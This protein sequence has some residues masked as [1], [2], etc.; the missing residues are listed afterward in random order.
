MWFSPFL[1]TH[2]LTCHHSSVVGASSSLEAEFICV[3]LEKWCCTCPEKIIG[4]K[5]H[6][7]DLFK[8]CLQVF[9][10][11]CFSWTNFQSVC[12]SK[13]WTFG[14]IKSCFQILIILVHTLYVGVTNS[15]CK[16]FRHVDPS[17]HINSFHIGTGVLFHCFCLL[18]WMVGFL[19]LFLFFF[20]FLCHYKKS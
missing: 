16:L 5:V 4:V 11:S 13:Q 9:M 17:T 10:A 3:I 1:G 8:R 7:W 6:Y 20:N 14:P 15:L 12:W 18:L 2:V 19:F